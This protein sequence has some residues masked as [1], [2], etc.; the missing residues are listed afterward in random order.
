MLRG[1]QWSLIVQLVVV[2]YDPWAAGH[3]VQLRY[4]V[5]VQDLHTTEGDGRNR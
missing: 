3:R 5:E 4:Q 1:A 2:A